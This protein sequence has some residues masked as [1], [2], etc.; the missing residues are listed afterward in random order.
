MPKGIS[1]LNPDK[2]VMIK[3]EIE[4]A[5][6]ADEAVLTALR[7]H[8]YPLTFSDIERLMPE[9]FQNHEKLSRALGRLIKEGRVQ[10]VFVITVGKA[11]K[12]Y[13]L[14]TDTSMLV[15]IPVR[16]MREM[17]YEVL[18]GFGY[19]EQKEPYDLYEVKADYILIHI[20]PLKG[21]DQL[22]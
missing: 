5:K 10:E 14:M 2:E 6:S 3:M 19:E 16:L 8:E 4:D 9:K 18:L 12:A 22:R 13:A 7:I 17:G 1:L 15:S 20:N 21:H 11:V